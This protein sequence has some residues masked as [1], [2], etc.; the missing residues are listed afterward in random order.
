MSYCA[1][2]QGRRK[3]TWNRSDILFQWSRFILNLLKWGSDYYKT[4]V[5]IAWRNLHFLIGNLNRISPP[6]SPCLSRW[7]AWEETESKEKKRQVGKSAT[8]LQPQCNRHRGNQQSWASLWLRWARPSTGQRQTGTCPDVPGTLPCSCSSSGVAGLGSDVEEK[9]CSESSSLAG[10]SL[11]FAAPSTDASLSKSE[12]LLSGPSPSSD[13]E[14]EGGSGAEWLSVGC[15]GFCHVP[16][17][18]AAETADA[19]QPINTVAGWYSPLGMAVLVPI[20]A[21]CPTHGIWKT[22]VGDGLRKQTGSALQ[23]E[24]LGDGMLVSGERSVTEFKYCL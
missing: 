2:A 16:K 24:L 10:R 18:P 5:G 15:G 22:Q 3:S 21:C 14:H 19:W 11:C 20:P 12:L 9:S 8:M 7:V 6:A 23:I 4:T 17:P 13:G 1:Q